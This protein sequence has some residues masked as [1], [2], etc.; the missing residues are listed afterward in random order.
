MLIAAT[1][2]LLGARPSSAVAQPGPSPWERG[3]GV[4]NLLLP[5][6]RSL[7][8]AIARAQRAMAKEE[9]EEAVAYLGRV[10]VG[11]DT[12]EAGWD[13][14]YFTPGAGDVKQSLKTQA[15]R[16]L[17]NAPPTARR[18]FELRYG[19]AAQRT[20]DDAV[21]QHDRTRLRETARRYALTQAGDR[22]AVLEAELLLDEGRA[23]AAVALLEQTLA[24][25]KDTEESLG[26][27]R[28]WLAAAEHVAG[29]A[30]DA[31]ELLFRHR[32]IAAKAPFHAPL[33]P[34]PQAASR[35]LQDWLAVRTSETSLEHW[36]THRGD[37]RGNG[38]GPADF[39][40]LLPR[41]RL[42]LH[43]DL[44][45]ETQAEE[46]DRGLQQLGLATVPAMH[47][48]A[49]GDDVLVRTPQALLAINARDGVR[50]WRRR[51]GLSDF[52]ERMLR[53]LGF[54]SV[55]SKS[56]RTLSVRMWVDSALGRLSS[57]GERVYLVD[58]ET[59]SP[60]GMPL[61]GRS[62]T[63][64]ASHRLTALDLERDGLPLWTIGGAPNAPGEPETFFLGP[65][66]CWDQRLFALSEG[67][68]EIR[69]GAYDPA[70]GR[71]IWRQPIAH[72][73]NLTIHR[74]AF[75]RYAAAS[76]SVSGGVLVCP[77]VA[78]LVVGVNVAQ[79]GLQW[80]YQYPNFRDA[81]SR[82]NK[83]VSP[84]P[85][86]P[87]WLDATATLSQG[88]VLLTPPDSDEL[89]CLALQTGDL[90]W[91]APREEGLYLAAVHGPDVVVVGRRQV[92][93]FDLDNGEP[94]W[95][96]EL[97]A[98]PA[99]LGFRQDDH[100]FVPLDNDTLCRIRLTDGET[101]V[102]RAPS[103]LGNL[104]G[105]RDQ[106]IS[107]SPASVQSFH[108]SQALRRDINLRLAETNNDPWARRWRAALALDAD[109][110][111]DAAKQLAPL[112]ESSSA[113]SASQ[114]LLVHAALKWQAED[115][116]ASQPW[117]DRAKPWFHLDD[118]MRYER[119]R[120]ADA[121]QRQ[122]FD[123]ALQAL[124]GFAA[125]L[126]QL[127]RSEPMSLGDARS[128][129]PRRWLAARI[130]E[131][132]RSTAPDSTT[133]AALRT[134]CEEQRQVAV[135]GGA[136]AAWRLLI[137]QFGALP[138]AASLRLDF[139]K[140]QAARGDWLEAEWQAQNALDTEDPELAP[141][142]TRFIESLWRRTN[143]NA[144]LVENNT[145]PTPSGPVEASQ[146]GE[147]GLSY[148]RIRYPLSVVFD[149]PLKDRMRSATS[150]VL[151]RP[152]YV[153]LR[154]RSGSQLE[155]F[156]MGVSVRS[157][158]YRTWRLKC[159]GHLLLAAALG[160][161]SPELIAVDTL[162]P[163]HNNASRV[164]WRQSLVGK[165]LGA[166]SSRESNTEI[167]RPLGVKEVRRKDDQSRDLTYIG[168][169][170]KNG[171]AF[172]RGQTLVCCD[173]LNGQVLWSRRDLAGDELLFGSGAWIVA[174]N[175]D[176]TQARRFRMDDGSEGDACPTRPP[177]TF[178][179]SQGALV[180]ALVEGSE[181]HTLEVWRLGQDEPEWRATVSLDAKAAMAGDDELLVSD[182]VG[183][184]ML[185]SLSETTAATDRLVFRT[186]LAA[187]DSLQQVTA[188][189]CNDGV[190]AIRHVAP[191]AANDEI[192][193]YAAPGYYPLIFGDLWLLN[194]DGSS[195]WPQPV[196]LEHYSF[197]TDQPPGSP[198][199]LLMR[200]E[201][202]GGVSYSRVA[203]VDRRDGSLAAFLERKG[204][205]LAAY[206]SWYSPSEQTLYLHDSHG[207]YA[208]RWTPNDR[209]PKPPAFLTR[210]GGP[211]KPPKLSEVLGKAAR[212]VASGLQRRD[213][214][215]QIGEAESRR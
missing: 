95:K 117:V 83:F 71:A 57:D 11:D 194:R 65:P 106:W 116:Q 66:L 79:R 126:E 148:S 144:R 20:F 105:W 130:G 172:R 111:D 110:P 167:Q 25:R 38:A 43:I 64:S 199:F 33:L 41:W 51:E 53:E 154:D 6:P 19:A 177:R 159:R 132:W 89:H 54:P 29:R 47:A 171:V 49:V 147:D 197:P 129:A 87:Y 60:T 75:R 184:T 84:S 121:M 187:I 207:R 90:L 91:K 205:F 138:E 161:G 102:E 72:V 112:A 104:V 141:E 128:V 78:G 108:H 150:F 21:R 140:R 118:T 34:N 115:A 146:Q 107:V 214:A 94:R 26:K 137:D 92:A 192:D 63:K 200:N 139:A 165:P 98:P 13:A 14:D 70:T 174:C 183:D 155:R 5:P 99:G 3:G 114:R 158:A 88:R 9:F 123:E 31:A 180:A 96:H 131:L 40:A 149:G 103:E 27:A 44:Q 213:N 81:R 181:R 58:P 191:P 82:P 190:V 85:W 145:T 122:A 50:R 101:V 175:P 201:R 15:R 211:P 209:P 56:W 2:F 100:Y 46:M 142:A 52:R 42:P 80:A 198:G 35:W 69:V 210:T 22:A 97:D 182:S 212:S 153:V 61:V 76:P 204:K 12:S 170:T 119:L 120:W 164:L 7:T 10:L 45:P 36:W 193:V 151:E 8:T 24:G 48:L 109:R 17:A 157:D 176:A 93:S 23:E 135:R 163:N 39:A 143:R 196:R 160:A 179:A 113:T 18:L 73:E 86:R 28:V 166:P 32:A 62:R 136:A 125:V 77:T 186:R 134:W 215:P 202:R 124:R 169:W 188:F 152:I 168:P 59:P 16:M 208:F 173:P 178:V 55:A 37:A 156:Y 4:R 189:R 195:R 185:I 162:S 127:P 203:V 30:K 68:G 133:R 67:Q 74:E 206:Q 1:A